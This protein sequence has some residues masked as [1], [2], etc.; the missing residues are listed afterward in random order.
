M[1]PTEIE[2]QI[3]EA[4]PQNISIEASGDPLIWQASIDGDSV[5]LIRLTNLPHIKLCSVH[6][7]VS[8]GVLVLTG[9]ACRH[10]QAVQP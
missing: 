8:D 3:R 2:K 10:E 6:R 9:F 1:T 5:D 4:I 7:R